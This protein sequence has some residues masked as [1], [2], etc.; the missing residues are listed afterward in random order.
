MSSEN[1][2]NILDYLSDIL[3][4]C[5]FKNDKNEVLYLYHELR[6]IK[7]NL[8]TVE[9]L[10]ELRK[11]AVDLE[12]KYDELNDLSYYFGPL[13]SEIRKNIHESYVK[14]LREGNKKREA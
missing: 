14:K 5:D 13:D 6:K 7:A 4:Q 8:P 2:S 3:N 10:D 1:L 12:V 9:K 11:K